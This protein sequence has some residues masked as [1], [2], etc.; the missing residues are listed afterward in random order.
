MTE[1]TKQC[2]FCAET[3][4]EEAIVCRFC[5]KELVPPSTEEKKKKKGGLLKGC[6][7]TGGIVILLFILLMIFIP[8]SPDTAT[9]ESISSSPIQEEVVATSA[10]LAP[11]IEEIFETVEGMTDAQRNNYMESLEGN[12]VENWKGTVT[13]VDEGEIL[14]GFS[15]FVEMISSNFSSEV[16]IDVSEEVALSLNKGQ[17]I[18]FSGVIRSVSDLFGTT[19]FIDN[20]TIEIVE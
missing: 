1:Q 20:A 3:I 9:Q 18:L 5:N 12:I 17:A 14:G 13:E 16:S 7:I 11:S 4:K 2:P 19:V 10:P 6:L 8:D 15:V